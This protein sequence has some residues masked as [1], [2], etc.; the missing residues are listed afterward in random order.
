MNDR[1]A[2]R[3]LSAAVGIVGPT[4]AMAEGYRLEDPE[5]V[6]HRMVLA[7]EQPALVEEMAETACLIDTGVEVP[8]HR[9]LLATLQTRYIAVAEALRNGDPELDV[10]SPEIHSRV[11]K[12][13]D[14]AEATWDGGFSAAVER[15][16]TS[17]ILDDNDRAV[18][19]DGDK[20]V[21]E[22]LRIL[23][24]EVEATYSNPNEVTAA[25]V[26]TLDLATR[27]EL[28]VTA[29]AK[30]VCVLNIG[31][32]GQEGRLTLQEELDLFNK[33]HL[34]LRD[35]MPMA[36]IDPPKPEIVAA[37][38]ALKA[39]WDTLEPVVRDAI[40]GEQMTKEAIVAFGDDMISLMGQ[41]H[42]VVKLYEGL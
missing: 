41:M 4:W 37:L 34:V 19:Y 8:E 20:A 35:G 5:L 39:N 36:G 9:A 11:I 13:L 26:L 22:T 15:V 1:V 30:E 21:V 33:T 31:W 14:A 24:S 17:G 32:R 40:A 6:K 29:M 10:M 28:L 23:A 42:E 12:A 38:D 2:S 18:L 25:S 27:Q 3:L 16:V 7:A